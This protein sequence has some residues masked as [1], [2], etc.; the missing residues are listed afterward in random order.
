MNQEI[1]DLIEITRFADQVPELV[2]GAGGNTSVKSQD[3]KVIHIKASGFCLNE[4]NETTGHLALNLERLLRIVEDKSYNSLDYAKQ[5]ERSATEM[6]E[7]SIEQSPIRPSLETGFHAILAKYVIHTH[8]IYVNALTCAEDADRIRLLKTLEDKIGPVIWI[9][10]RPPGHPL[11]RLIAD[12]LKGLKAASGSMP[13]TILL[14]NHGLIT[15]SDSMEEAKALHAN[16]IA[17]CTEIFGKLNDSEYKIDL[18]EDKKIT[19][20]LLENYPCVKACSDK[21]INYALKNS[22]LKSSE[23]KPLVPDDAVYWGNSI[24]LLVNLVRPA[25]ERQGIIITQNLDTFVVAQKES[26]LKP[27]E[28]SFT[29]NIRIRLIARNHAKISPLSEEQIAFITG[30]EGEKYRQALGAKIL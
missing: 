28:D 11:A 3:N 19:S 4:L 25:T 29:A 23:I 17:A 6:K 10:Y 7:C 9:N 27:I 22:I 13:C 16:C 12:S 5:Q 2:Q 24:L 18:A 15:S 21:Y 26:L 1:K 14:K 20:H 8:P 30:M